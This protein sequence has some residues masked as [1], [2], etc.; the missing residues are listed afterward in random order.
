VQ[1][2]QPTAKPIPAD[3]LAGV[4]EGFYGQ[5]WTQAERFE[6]FDWMAGWGLNTYLYAPKDDL[7]H[8]AVWRELYSTTEQEQLES[9]IR[10]CE[11]HRIRFIYGLS[12]GLDMRYGDEADLDHLMKRFEQMLGSG[13]Q[14]FALLFDDIPDRMDATA[15]KRWGSLGSAQCHVANAMFRWTRERSPGARFLFCPTAYCGRMAE[16]KHGGEG[17]LPTI[18]RELSPEIDVFWTGPEIISREITLAH[19]QELQAVLRRKP[20]IWDNLHAN[21]YDGRRF[22]CG[23][24]AGR[25]LEL[26]SA[27]SGLLSNPNNELPL[28]Y[29]P[30]RTLAEFARCPGAAGWD[31][32]QAYLSAMREWLQ[33]FA[34]IGQPVTLEDL[35]LFG[36]CYYLPHEEGPEAEALYE[37]A[38]ALLTGHPADWDKQAAAFRQQIGRLRQ[39]CVRMTELRHR[40]LFYALSRR[41]WELREE[42]ELLERYIAF[43]SSHPSAEALPGS[44]F[45]LPGTYRG[46][47]VARLQR[48]LV[49][50]GDGTFGRGEV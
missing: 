49:Q 41:L 45:H 40:P 15:I 5:P 35:I 38:S 1:S 4:I 3:F 13:C 8:R 50:R 47:M 14:N 46:G 48:L 7:K 33:R 2:Q 39:F 27:V 23:P 20:L 36:D 10:A 34:T 11:Q 17:Y 16:R 12:P 43:K 29:V 21:D 37:R 18:G 22:F 9:L 25:P 28:N 31:A 32:R 6:L 44:D 26:R 19:I 24:Y 42:L 30:L